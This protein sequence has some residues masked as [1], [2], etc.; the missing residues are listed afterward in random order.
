MHKNVSMFF[1]YSI[2]NKDHEE[3]LQYIWTG[4]SLVSN[5][6]FGKLEVLCTLRYVI[7][8][9]H[10]KL[11]ARFLLKHTFFFSQNAGI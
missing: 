11:G 2:Q 10:T 3:M 4:A 6:L 5:S 1:H 7:P 9:F 8:S